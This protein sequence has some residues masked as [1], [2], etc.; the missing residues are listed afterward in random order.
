MYI[1]YVVID[2]CCKF[3][4]HLLREPGNEW[5]LEEAKRNLLTKYLLVGVT[6][7]LQ[8]FIA[9]LESAIPT[10]FRG[11]LDHFKNSKIKY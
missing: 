8:D 1:H 11:A 10:F 6:E 9:I 2:I 7:E 5:A 3:I 4:F